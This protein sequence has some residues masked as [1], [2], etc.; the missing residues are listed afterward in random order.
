LIKIEI[1]KILRPVHG[2]EWRTRLRLCT[3][4]GIVAQGEWSLERAFC[5][6]CCE[7]PP[8]GPFDRSFRR[9]CCETYLSGARFQTLAA[10]RVSDSDGAL[11]KADR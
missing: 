5:Q 1:G 8:S 10:R 9:L 3:H 6:P 2:L 11:H 7:P 4:P